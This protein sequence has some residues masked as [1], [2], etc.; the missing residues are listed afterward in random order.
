VQLDENPILNKEGLFLKIPGV[1]ICS[2]G[3]I[4]GSVF[5]G[6]SPPPGL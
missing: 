4:A 2:A 3:S 5:I 6:H 1:Q